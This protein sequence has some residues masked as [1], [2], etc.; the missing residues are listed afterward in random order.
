M[1]N[2]YGNTTP[3]VYTNPITVNTH[4][5]YTASI[6]NTNR[7]ATLS[8]LLTLNDD[9]FV[10]TTFGAAYTLN[11]GPMQVNGNRTITKG[12]SDN[13]VNL[14]GLTTLA[15]NLTLRHT[16]INVAAGGDASFN[17]SGGTTG[18]GN[19][20]ISSES[21]GSPMT[22]STGALNH[23]GTITNSGTSVSGVTISAPIGAAVTAITQSS[24][25][26]TMTLNGQITVNATATTIT[27][28]SALALPVNGGATGTGNLILNANSTGSMT[29]ATG[30][31]NF[32]GTITNSGTGSGAV[33][34]SSVIGSNVTGVAQNSTT[35]IFTLSGANTF[36]SGV[37]IVSGGILVAGG[38]GVAGVSGPLGTGTTTV[39]SGAELRATVGNALLG[40]SSIVLAGGTL[41]S[42]SGTVALV[43]GGNV[44][45]TADS[46]VIQERVGTQSSSVTFGTLAIGTNTLNA[47]TTNSQSLNFGA[48]NFGA[49]TLSGDPAFNVTRNPALTDDTQLILG[50]VSG[51]TS[52]RTITY[53]GNG[54]FALGTP[55]LAADLTVVSAAPA[56][57]RSTTARRARA[58]SCLT[59]TPR[60][61]WPPPVRAS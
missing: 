33:A 23:A 7:S 47:T 14:T 48:V 50:A 30:G 55:A 41:H 3:I 13:V 10:D 25:T 9:V 40:S 57:R 4:T 52:A 27:N 59:P 15:G 11:F 1:V 38:A 22:L 28:G 17:M 61:R 53:T 6:V 32:A 31:V 45:V 43:T 29:L 42:L 35:S 34:I 8:G 58:T 20:V 2:F 44:T 51:I 12:T 21:T 36:T 39:G 24:A 49:T 46:T 60:A 18:T 54:T 5:G 37:T 56:P 16:G 26:S 19:L